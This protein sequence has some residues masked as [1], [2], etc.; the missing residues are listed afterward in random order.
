[1]DCAPLSS[2]YHLSMGECMVLQ[3]LVDLQQ[4]FQS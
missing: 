4:R 3:V 1:M 2:L